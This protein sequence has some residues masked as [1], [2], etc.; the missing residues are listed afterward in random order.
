MKNR[1]PLWLLLAG[2]VA[3]P[4]AAQGTVPAAKGVVQSP[5]AE[6]TQPT[7][8]EDG[9]LK[10]KLD[11]AAFV[12]K[13]ALAGLSEVKVAQM[14]VKKATTPAIREFAAL[15][16]KDHGATN[17][18]LRTTAQ[19]LGVPVPTALDAAR[20]NSA[21]RLAGLTGA[22]FDAAYTNMM[23]QDHD[24]AVALF[25]NAA[26]DPSLHN[27]LRSF[28]AQALDTL[29]NHQLQAH[30]LTAEEPQSTQK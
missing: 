8:S 22:E 3:L 5:N 10:A 12:E 25:E 6:A 9:K 1:A 19:R 14:A 15:M 30:N 21:D 26:G 4:V 7:G 11:N 28:A 20:R 18:R 24:A 16:L 23:K 2:C 29:R 17:Q 13:A 27:D